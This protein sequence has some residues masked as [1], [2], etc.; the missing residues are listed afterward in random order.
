MTLSTTRRNT[1]G[2]G[3]AAVA[4]GSCVLSPVGAHAHPD[5]D[6][7]RL[8]ARII[9]IE[10]EQATLFTIRHTLDDEARTDPAMNAL[11]DERD[12]VFDQLRHLLRPTT[13]DG[14]RAVA[15][16]SLALAPRANNGDILWVG[17]SER[18]AWSVAD[19]LA[20][21]PACTT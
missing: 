3:A 4:S 19:Y 2:F 13:I 18:L 20:G 11:Y 10:A 15:R 6:L 8:C 12:Q 17:D 14:A 5:A 9:A 7:I 16:A 1:L 21:R